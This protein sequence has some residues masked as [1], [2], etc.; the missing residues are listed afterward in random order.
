[1]TPNWFNKDVTLPDPDLRLK[2]ALPLV[3]QGTVGPFEVLGVKPDTWGSVPYR[4][5]VGNESLLITDDSTWPVLVCV[6]GAAG[7]APEAHPV[8]SAVDHVID[9]AGMRDIAAKQVYIQT[10]EPNPDPTVVPGGTLLWIDPTDPE[11]V[12]VK[13]GEWVD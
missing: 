5:Y 11:N 9:I 6:R 10:D 2:Y 3:A 7:T 4:L 8:K 12:L 1:M 13:V